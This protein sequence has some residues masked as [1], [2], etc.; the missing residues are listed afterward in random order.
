MYMQRMVTISY[1]RFGTER[2]SRNVSKELVS[3]EFRENRHREE[4]VI[5]KLY[6]LVSMQP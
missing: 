4:H 6:L 2:L 1:G 3:C 5:L